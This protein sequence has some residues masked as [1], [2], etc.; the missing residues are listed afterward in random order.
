MEA[1]QV[2]ELYASNFSGCL[3]LRLHTRDTPKLA[4]MCQWWN[5]VAISDY[6]QPGSVETTKIAELHYRPVAYSYG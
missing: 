3:H 1:H 4:P 5:G 6:C 2:L